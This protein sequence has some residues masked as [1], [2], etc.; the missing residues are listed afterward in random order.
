MRPLIVLVL[1]LIAAAALIFTFL[2]RTEDRKSPEIIEPGRTEVVAPVD[3][4]PAATLTDTPEERVA[5]AVVPDKLTE[6]P[7]EAVAVADFENGLTGQ[8]INEEGRPVGEA[9]V[10]LTFAN[11]QIMMLDT[12]PN[13]TKNIEVTS[14]SDGRFTF[15]HLEP[16]D[17]YTLIV[18]H[19]DYSRDEISNVQV[20]IDGIAEEPAIVLR[21]GSSLS[22]YLRDK[23]GVPITKAEIIL[24]VN[25]MGPVG[26]NAQR[27]KIDNGGKYIIQN[28]APGMRTLRVMADGYGSQFHG[29]LSFDGKNS[30]TKD[31]ELEVAAIIAGR[32]LNPSGDGEPGVQVMA[33]NYSNSTRHSRDSMK[34]KAD[35]SFSLER[36][37]PGSYTLQFAKPGFKRDRMLRVE[38]GDLNVTFQL[39]RRAIVSGTVIDSSTGKPIPAGTVTLRQTMEGTELTTRTNVTGKIRNGKYELLDVQGGDYLVEAIAPKYGLAATFSAPFTVVE[40]QDVNGIDIALTA[41]GT[42]TGRVMDSS[43][44]GIA[45]AV[46]GTHENDFTTDEFFAT[47]GEMFPNNI[48]PQK[49]RT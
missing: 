33:I 17:F 46:V 40:G 47:F 32:V 48:T 39:A 26:K 25:P 34:T 12:T 9:S 8:I 14:D 29:G 36:L 3:Q 5:V 10:T 1:V 16:S 21:Q 23:E 6:D 35:G 37:N 11:S 18:T 30:R 43:G 20:P 22:G 41:G 31:L 4:G 2:L 24:D 13:K 45:G 42:I 44:K 15:V 27:A 49:V 38:T 28:V 7:V 19:P